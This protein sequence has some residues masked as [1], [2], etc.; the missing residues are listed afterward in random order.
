[1]DLGKVTEVESLFPTNK[2]WDTEKGFMPWRAVRI[3]VGFSI[4]EDLRNTLCG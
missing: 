4:V 2:E 3:V 1:M